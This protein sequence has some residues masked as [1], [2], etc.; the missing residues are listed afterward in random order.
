MKNKLSRIKSPWRRLLV[1]LVLSCL[2]FIGIFE[3]HRSRFH[4]VGGRYRHSRLERP[5]FILLIFGAILLLNPHQYIHWSIIWGGAFSLF[6]I[7]ETVRKT[8]QIAK[9]IINKD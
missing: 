3:S 1:S 4:W 7:Y 5:L 9:V 6:T 8:A 2:I